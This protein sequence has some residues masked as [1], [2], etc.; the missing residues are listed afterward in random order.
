MSNFRI[1]IIAVFAIFAVI[2]VVAFS[3]IGG[4][5]DND[6]GKVEIWGTAPQKLMD[7]LLS[8]INT[9]SDNFVGVSYTQ[10]DEKTYGDVFVE[11]LASDSGPDLFLLPHDSIVQYQNKIIEIPYK[12]F[13]EREFK[14][15]FI[16]EGELYLTDSGVLG[17]PFTIDPMIM[18]WNRDIFQNTGIAEPPRYWD[19]LFVLSPKITQRDLASNITRS[20]V[21]LGEFSNVENA[22]EILSAF[23]IQSGNP[24]IASVNG[25]LRSIIRENLGFTTSPTEAAVRFYTEFSNPVK[26]VYSW[27]RALPNSKQLFASGDL[28]IYF[29]F[30]SELPEII[31]MNPNLN[32]DVSSLP[33]LRDS[34]RRVTYGKMSAF[35]VPRA[36]RNPTGAF[37]VGLLLTDINNIAVFSSV[38]GLPPVRRDLLAGRPS[39]AFASVFYDSALISN[40][41]LEPDSTE[42]DDIFRN[43]VES[44]TSGRARLSEAIRIAD[45]ELDLLLRS[46]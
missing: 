44:V 33:Q 1:I 9:E 6:I 8:D 37:I 7:G 17:F 36:S 19:E 16:Q 39:D 24:I 22:K 20:F 34:D 29:G 27:N 13:S 4:G 14:N 31:R 18:Y 46:R 12:N 38:T 40:A 10:K 25:E 2:G 26:S 35:A 11:A 28:A 15:T 32:F 3:G 5:E 42:A 23:I 21:A 45:E 30:A 43:M 41:W